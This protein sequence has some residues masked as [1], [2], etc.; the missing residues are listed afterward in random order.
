MKVFVEIDDVYYSIDVA[1]N[2][3]FKSCAKVIFKVPYFHLF[4]RLHNRFANIVVTPVKTKN[5]TNIYCGGQN[6]SH[7]EYNIDNNNCLLLWNEIY[8]LSHSSNQK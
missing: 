4:H 5:I 2:N 6:K 1:L 7:L 3:K 8:F